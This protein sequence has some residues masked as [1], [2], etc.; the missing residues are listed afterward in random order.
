MKDDII[1]IL[2][3][4]DNFLDNMYDRGAFDCTDKDDKELDDFI[5]RMKDKYLK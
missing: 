4:F 2:T 3:R 5:T 1:E